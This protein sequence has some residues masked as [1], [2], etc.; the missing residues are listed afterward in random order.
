M[1]G[2]LL[3]TLVLAGLLLAGPPAGAAAQSFK[4]WQTERFQ[5]ELALSEEQIARLE[6]IFQSKQPKLREQKHAL[7]RLEEG[8]SRLVADGQ[9]DEAEAIALIDRV[10]AAR[11]ALSKSRTL[12]LFKMRRILTSDQH[13]KLKV[14]HQEWERERRRG[15][16]NRESHLH[17]QD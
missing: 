5:K 1:Q 8:L 9:A 7:D 14:L 15:G 10:E 6:Q 2:K 3:A 12:M 13:V 11:S 16:R 17:Q 4:W